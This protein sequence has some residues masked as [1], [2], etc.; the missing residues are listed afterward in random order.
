M[1]LP[2]SAQQLRGEVYAHCAVLEERADAEGAY[3]HVRGEEE[4][5]T[6]GTATGQDNTT[7]RVLTVPFTGNGGPALLLIQTSEASWDQAAVDDFIAS[8]R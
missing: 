4:T 7:M 6:L 1:F 2:W 8:F 3:F 5:G